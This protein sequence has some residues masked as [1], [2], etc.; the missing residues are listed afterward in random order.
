MTVK[1]PN[2]SFAESAEAHSA[3]SEVCWVLL[4]ALVSLVILFSGLG[5]ASLFEPDEGRNAEK[6]REILLLNDFVTPHQNFLPTLDKPMF[7]YWLIAAAF[8]VF[9][10]SEAAARLPSALAA[11]GCLILVYRFAR[12][13]WGLWE[14]LWSCLVL[15]TSLQFFIYARLVI[16]DMTLTF[17]ITWSL[18]AFYGIAESRQQHPKMSQVMGLY[19]ALAVGTLIKGPIALIAPGMVI[20]FFLLFTRNWAVLKRIHLMRGLTVYLAIVTP[21]YVWAEVRNPGYLRYFLW[22]EHLMRYLTPRFGRSKSWYYFF[23]VIGFGF[24]P[25][26]LLLPVTVKRLWQ[27]TLDHAHLFLVLWVVLTFTFFSVSSSKLPHYVLPIYPALAILVGH[28]VSRQ[29]RDRGNRPWLV[30]LAPWVFVLGSMI[31]LCTAI[32]LPEL[33]AAPVRTAV[34]ASVRLIA[35]AALVLLLIFSV[36]V[37]SQIK[38]GWQDHGSTYLGTAVG[39]ALFVALLVQ[40][41][42][43]SSF[44]RVS[45]PLA[46]LS[47][48]FIGAQDRLVFYDTFLE[49][50]PFYLRVEK[51]IWVV[52]TRERQSIMASNYLAAR[53]PAPALGYGPVVLAFDEFA[54]RWQAGNESLRVIVKEKNLARLSQEVGAVPQQLVRFGEYLLVGNR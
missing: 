24:L 35:A 18:L 50:I 48:P 19:V 42:A 43:A 1:R 53:R 13:Q 40:I 20:F 51:P 26:S 11:L 7:F 12:R 37:F 52:Q 34:L 41:V 23:M 9:G 45:K 6:A 44:N 31:Y 2:S 28:I 49:G 3:G 30:A 17:F 15:V 36:L 39:L 29:L 27:N 16:L 46:Q 21:W 47:A 32:G 38:N 54:A 8:R 10:A 4:L 25:W 14:A 22:D 33:M 5:S